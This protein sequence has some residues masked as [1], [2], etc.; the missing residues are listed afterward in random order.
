MHSIL[1]DN[2]QNDAR[3]RAWAAK[4]G[5]SPGVHAGFGIGRTKMLRWF[6]IDARSWAFSMSMALAERGMS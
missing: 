3:S 1:H 4:D 5:S 2:G 6:Y